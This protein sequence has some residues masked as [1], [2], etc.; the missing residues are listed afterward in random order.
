L[1]HTFILERKY[2]KGN[3][4]KHTTANRRHAHK[5]IITG[6][7]NSNAK[8]RPLHY[9]SHFDALVYG[10]YADILNT[11][12]NDELLA[13]NDLNEAVLAY[14]KIEIFPESGK[15]KAN[16]HFAKECFDE[17]KHRAQGEEVC[18]LAIDLKSFFSTLDH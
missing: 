14:R 8:L 16:I 10:Y 18:V 9:A 5:E 15:G 12:Y 13:N 1:M 2:K 17:I 11:K 6:K 3:P 4:E 7:T